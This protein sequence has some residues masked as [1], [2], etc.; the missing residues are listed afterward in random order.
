MR[1]T[2]FE[3]RRRV[4]KREDRRY[5][6]AKSIGIWNGWILVVGGL[7]AAFIVAAKEEDGIGIAQRI[8]GVLGCLGMS[9]DRQ[10]VV[11]NS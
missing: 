1:P 5:R 10:V 9:L 4:A 8:L 11:E 7:V 6:D 3:S 2:P